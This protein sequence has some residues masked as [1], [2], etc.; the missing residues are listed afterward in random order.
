M[1]LRPLILPSLPPTHAQPHLHEHYANDTVRAL[2]HRQDMSI[3]LRVAYLLDQAI[4]MCGIA[5]TTRHAG[6][7]HLSSVGQDWDGA[8]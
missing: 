4:D 2:H 8:R 1:L 5:R 7:K 6:D 3:C